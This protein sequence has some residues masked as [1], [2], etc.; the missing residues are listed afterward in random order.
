MSA[1]NMNTDRIVR[2]LDRICW[3]LR[4]V[5]RAHPYALR[6]TYPSWSAYWRIHVVWP[7]EAWVVA[8]VLAAARYRNRNPE[9][10]E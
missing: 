4:L 3:L 9:R 7:R 2:P 6:D 10:T 8:G 1:D 5:G